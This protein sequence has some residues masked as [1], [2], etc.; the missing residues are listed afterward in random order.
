MSMKNTEIDFIGE[1]KIHVIRGQ[2]VMLDSDLARLY[3]VETKVLNQAV[4]RNLER[5]PSDFMFQLVEN[6]W[7]ILRSQIVTLRLW[8]EHRKYI[9]MAFTQ[10]G[11][12]MLSGVLRSETAIRV[13]IEIM[14]AFVKMKNSESENGRAP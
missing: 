2:R 8:G 7:E 1:I 10:E 11:V 9:P 4:R 6:E 13:N 14:R 3:G 12:A 5:F